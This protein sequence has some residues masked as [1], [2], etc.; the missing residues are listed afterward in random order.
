MIVYQKCALIIIIFMSY[1]WCDTDDQQLSNVNARFNHL[2]FY[3]LTPKQ[4]AY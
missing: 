1:E 2:P 3:L 4:G